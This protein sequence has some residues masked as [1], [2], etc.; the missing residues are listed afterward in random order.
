[1]INVHF[2]NLMLHFLHSMDFSVSALVLNYR[3]PQETVNC[4]Q[5]LLKQSISDQLEIIVID[6]HSEDDSIGVLRNRLQKFDH[7]KIIE[8]P[9]NIGYGQGNNRGEHYAAGEYTFI[10]NPDNQLEPDG[11]EK[12]IDVL[13]KDSS[14]GIIAP[15]LVFPDGT[16]RDS[17]R[18][19]P[20][21]TDVFIKRT[22]LRNLFPERLHHYT[23]EKDDHSQIKEVDWVVGAC[24]LMR[25]DLF[26]QLGG[27]DPRF[28]PFFEDVD[29]CRRVHQLG[30][31][32]LYYPEVKA[33]DSKSRLSQGGILA[34]FTK[35]TVREHLRS[36]LRYFGKWRIASNLKF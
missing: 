1:M 32:V 33:M 21:L 2:V 17:Y 35:W 20:T 24:L 27:F 7:I 25:R 29:L 4:V 19:F 12:M 14:I 34:L 8:T 26:D 10:T 36:A 30:K 6:N 16:I 28:F 5:A 15:Q 18:R 31:K 9:Q 3:S 22:F 23:Q 11:L 13:Q